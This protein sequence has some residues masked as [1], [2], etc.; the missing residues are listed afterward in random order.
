MELL[1][2]SPP[3]AKLDPDLLE[4]PGAFLWWY[5]DMVND[6]GDGVVLIWSWGLPFLVGIA[7]AAR[8][9]APTPPSARP[10][11]NVAVYKGGELD[12]Y[13]LQE[14]SPSEATWDRARDESRFG[15][16]RI[17]RRR[18][19]SRVELNIDLD[20]ALPGTHDRL[21]GRVRISGIA[22][23]PSKAEGSNP[24]DP[25]H[26][27]TPV[28][29]PAHGEVDLSVGEKRYAFDARAYHD[30]NSGDA[31]LHE[32]GF[33]HW[34]WG[35]LARADRESIYYILWPS[36]GGPPVCVGLD[37][38]EDGTTEHIEELEVRLSRSRVELAGMRWHREIELSRGGEPWAHI[39][40]TSVI[41]NG[42]FYLRFMLSAS[43][44]GD[45]GQSFGIGE[46]C[47]PD[48][49]DLAR[50]R[51]LVKMA[52]GQQARGDDSIWRPL[53]TGPRE[54]RVKNLLRQLI[55]GAAK[56]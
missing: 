11:L 28:C 8:R 24:I 6:R 21:V 55:P 33:D 45:R 20:A 19:G 38:K 40:P 4:K 42:P 23:T 47:V 39:T 5:T 53:F 13:L 18:R 25:S 54:G 41:D 22:R 48:R 32:L 50:H 16:N 52:I 56:R 27:W 3:T 17:T 43:F 49:M 10:S 51:P 1:T 46:S 12:C 7:S 9:G 30:R 26:D 36:A 31:P 35:R 2:L 15:E 34:I 37:I 29:G 14:Y 44:P